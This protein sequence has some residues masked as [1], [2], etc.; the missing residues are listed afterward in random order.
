MWYDTRNSEC[1]GSIVQLS[2]GT[3]Y[4]VQFALP[5]QSP[6]RQLA[7][8][9]WSETFPVAS[10]VSVPS[11]SQPLNITKGG[12]AAGYVLYT[13]AASTTAT[14]DVGNA[15]ATDIT[16]SAPYVIVRGLTLKGAQSDAIKIADSA[17]DVVIEDNDISG[18][19]RSTGSNSSGGYQIGVNMDSGI[20]AVC[21][22]QNMVRVIVQRNRIH[23]PRYGANSWTDGHPMGPQALSFESC[24]G[25]HVIRQ[26]EI[27]STTGHYFNDGLGGAENFSNVGFPNADSDIYRNKISQTWDDGIE[28]EGG[29]KNIRIWG[30]Y[31]DQ[32]ATCVATTVVAVGP[33]YIFR[34]VYNRSR[35]LE[36]SSLDS[37]DRNG[38]AK[39]GDAGGFGGGRR[40]IFHNTLLQATQS[41]VTNGLGA[42]YG[43]SGTGSSQ[44]ISNTVSRNNIY[45]TWKSSYAAIQQAGASND[46]GYDLYNGSAGATETSGIQGTPIYLAGNGWSSE[47]G[48]LYQLATNSPGYDRGARIPNFNDG[49]IG[50]GPDIGAD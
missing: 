19:G 7:A 25:N 2:S 12:T 30:N 11:G 36:A 48:G 6:S 40:Y 50:A 38:F 20:H 4:E 13:P 15:S 27:Y 32:T 16:I 43:I 26:N 31:C 47:A 10:T 5:G 8:A 33:A 39:S 18:W 35:T 21:S 46:F 14:I 3:N 22:T 29:D 24:G 44:L 9:T 34:N 41:G 28:A 45:Q 37:D 49:F 23:D 17:H 1:R 42:A